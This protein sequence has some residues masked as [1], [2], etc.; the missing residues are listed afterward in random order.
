MT[1]TLRSPV[2]VTQMETITT[3][4]CDD[5]SVWKA[6]SYDSSYV[7]HESAPI[8]GSHRDRV[9]KAQNTPDAYKRDEVAR[10]R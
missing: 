3:V 1:D 7:W 8:P 2:G 5:G 9:L 4:I 6:N 10:D